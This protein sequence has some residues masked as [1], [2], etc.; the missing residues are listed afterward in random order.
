MKQYLGLKHA[1][2]QRTRNTVTHRSQKRWLQS[3]SPWWPGDTM[4]AQWLNSQV[5][6]NTFAIVCILV[7]RS[8]A[9]HAIL[10][11]SYTNQGSTR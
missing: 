8:I 1:D 4:T 5:Q 3:R 11:T 6:E 9:I 2:T 10:Y 7:L